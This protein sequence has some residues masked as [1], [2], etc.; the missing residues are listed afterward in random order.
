MIDIKFISAVA[1]TIKHCDTHQ[2]ALWFSQSMTKHKLESKI[3]LHNEVTKIINPKNILILGCWYPTIL[4]YLFYNAGSTII[5]VDA[6]PSLKRLSDIFNN[7][8]YD[9][10]PVQHIVADA[11]AFVK[12][13]D[14]SR[15][16]L[17]IN[18]SCE[19]MIFNMRDLAFSSFPLYAFQSN[20]YRI[21]EHINTKETLKEFV[22]STGL[23][24]IQYEDT[25]KSTKFDRFMVIGKYCD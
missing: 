19:H 10:N 2:E 20:N 6:D 5:C 18:T 11:E 16:D 1:H 4:P 21:S 15:F 9:K 7:Y 25:K 14:T 17:V 13:M 24:V 12:T 22:D 23:S 3:W 8:L